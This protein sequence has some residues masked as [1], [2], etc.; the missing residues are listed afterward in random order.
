MDD[1]TLDG[2]LDLEEDYYKKGYAEGHE[3]SAKEQFLEGKA[4][5]L[6][7]GF[8]RFLIVGYLKGLLEKWQ[9]LPADE[10]LQAHLRQLDELLSSI[11][12]TNGD[13]EV[14][15]YEKAV[16]KARNKARLV[17]TLTNTPA[18]VSKLDDQLKEVGGSMQVSENV[19]NM[20]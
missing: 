5:G 3:R 19:D 20:W 12:L 1:I 2:A 17:A 4:Y 15:Q 9:K 6:Q 10:K 18:S 14:E 13:S 8:Q 11:P 16:F 7:T